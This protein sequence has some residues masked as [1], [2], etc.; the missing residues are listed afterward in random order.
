MLFIGKILTELVVRAIVELQNVGAKVHGIVSDGATTNR[1]LWKNL[2]I[3]CK[4]G[5]ST[6]SFKN[7]AASDSDV[8]VFSD[9]P[10]LIKC[11][12][13]RLFTKR[14]LKFQG[15][16]IRWDYYEKLYAEDK[17]NGGRLK[18]CPKLTEQHI[19]PSYAL[20]MRVFLATQVK[21]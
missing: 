19:N 5:E 7:P 15:E 13:N 4:N 2:G 18:V 11:I 3:D 1:K 8:Y 6:H 12:R 20:K 10:H 9:V 17:K 16:Q 21:I 14:V